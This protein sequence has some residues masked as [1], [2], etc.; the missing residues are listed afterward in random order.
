MRPICA[1]AFLA[2]ATTVMTANAQAQTT[3]EQTAHQR[4]YGEIPSPTEHLG[5]IRPRQDRLGTLRGP[6][7]SLTQS[8]QTPYLGGT[9]VMR[10]TKNRA[11]PQRS[12]RHRHHRRNH[13]GY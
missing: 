1:F 13:V 3:P 10:A 8:S 9:A 11:V 7:G 2:L 4:H 5:E 12:R 6:Q